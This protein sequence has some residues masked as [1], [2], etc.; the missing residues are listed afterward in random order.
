MLEPRSH[1]ARYTELDTRADSAAATNRVQNTVNGLQDEI[2]SLKNQLQRTQSEKET[3]ENQAR[4]SGGGGIFGAGGFGSRHGGNGKEKA[5][6]LALENE[7]QALRRE[8]L[9]L[10]EQDRSVSWQLSSCLNN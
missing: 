2:K 6:I 4:L 10:M 7:M 3:L 5:I 1:R 8:N 9:R